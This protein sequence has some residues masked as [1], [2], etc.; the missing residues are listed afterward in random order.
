M[1]RTRK[2]SGS[3]PFAAA[4]AAAISLSQQDQQ[5]TNL[6]E[7]QEAIQLDRIQDRQQ[8]TRALRAEHVAA[9]AESIAIVGLIHPP[10]VDRQ[11]RL[12]AGGHRLAAL[13]QL[14]VE[15]RDRFQ[16]LFPNGVPVRR[17]DLDA[18]QDPDLAL[19]VEVSENERRRDY[20]PSE[21]RTLAERLQ[22][23]GF[24]YS[25][26]GGRPRSTSRAL[27]PALE[28]IVGKST[29]QIRRILNTEASEKTRTSVLVLGL[30]N[31]LRQTER[32]SEVIG[33][34][35]ETEELRALQIE[36]ARVKKATDR[37]I[38]AMRSAEAQ[39]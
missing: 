22:A 20:T 2:R 7:Q 39:K 3:D 19:A 9:L 37:A 35:A 6:R 1:A 25:K 32:L 29:R 18:E 5:L 36:L 13:R 21:V 14:A 24:Q 34:P 33:L 30:E 23:S 26:E 31:F 16:A 38:A 10:A 4:T 12:L 17:M 8:D 11:Y 28:L 15:N 27:M